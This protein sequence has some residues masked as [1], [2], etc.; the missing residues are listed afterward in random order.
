V[1]NTVVEAVF[2]D[3][4]GTLIDNTYFQVI[5]WSRACRDLGL[6]VDMAVLHRLFGVGA[7]QFIPL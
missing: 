1:L 3:V 5:A 4:G 2:F 7:D 6:N